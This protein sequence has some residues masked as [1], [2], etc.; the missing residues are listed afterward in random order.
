VPGIVRKAAIER[1]RTDGEEA[2]ERSP[3]QT[4]EVEDQTL[5]LFENGGEERF[6]LPL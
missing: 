4:A 2:V 3:A 6:A 1:I 5:L